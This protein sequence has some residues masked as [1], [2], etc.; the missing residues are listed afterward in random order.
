MELKTREYIAIGCFAAVLLYAYSQGVFSRDKGQQ[1]KP[2]TA[3]TDGS[4]AT[5][6]QTVAAPGGRPGGAAGEAAAPGTT[7]LKKKQ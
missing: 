7:P 5:D 3:V 2:G 4:A 1:V 6:K